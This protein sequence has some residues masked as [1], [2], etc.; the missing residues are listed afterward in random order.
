MD[1]HPASRCASA[2]STVH[3][4]GTS[5][6]RPDVRCLRRCGLCEDRTLRTRHTRDCGRYGC[7]RAVD[8]RGRP[9]A[10]G[11]GCL[12][13]LSSG[14]EGCSLAFARREDRDGC[15]GVEIKR[16]SYGSELCAGPSANVM[17]PSQTTFPSTRAMPRSRPI[18]LRSR[19]TSASITTTSPG[20]TGRR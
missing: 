16:C 19:R 18:R 1:P 20:W 14:V 4:G 15:A 3:Q 2:T 7:G 12:A 8:R 17:V 13:I 6:Q 10:S 11:A 9:G 5:L